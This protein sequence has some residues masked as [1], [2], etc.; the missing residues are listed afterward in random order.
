[1]SCSHVFEWCKRYKE[2]HEHME[3]DP[4]SVRPSKSRTKVN[5]QCIKQMVHSD[6]WQT[7][8]IR[9]GHESGQHLEDSH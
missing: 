9:T 7:D 4:R 6:H 3:D 1:M 5:I 2:G 8:G